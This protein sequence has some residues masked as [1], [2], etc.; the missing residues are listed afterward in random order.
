MAGGRDIHLAEHQ[1]TL[2]EAAMISGV[3]EKTIRNWLARGSLPIGLKHRLGR[4][5]FSTLDIIRLRV[6]NDLTQNELVPMKPTDAAHLAAVVA[7]RAMRATFRDPATGEL[8]DLKRDR[9]S[10]GC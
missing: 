4:W 2:A 5:L 6:M 1:F 3:P 8:D 9:L 10:G 7:D